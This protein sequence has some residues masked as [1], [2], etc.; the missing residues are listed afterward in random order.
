M[1]SEIELG[2]V[3][4]MDVKELKLDRGSILKV[5]QYNKI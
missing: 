4:E 3:I 2:K 5:L 1:D